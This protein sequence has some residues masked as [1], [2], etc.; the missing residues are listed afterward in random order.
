MNQTKRMILLGALA[1]AALLAACTPAANG[2]ANRASGS[3]ALSSDDALLYAVDTDNGILAVIDTSTNAK[4][5]EV[6]VGKGPTR[7]LVGADDTIYV[8]NRGERTVSVISRGDWRVAKTLD[9]AVEPSGMALTPDGKT[10]LVVSAT[11]RTL[12]E[13]G[14]LTAF[15]TSTLAM[16]WELNV[17]NEPRGV[18]VVGNGDRAVVSLLKSSR[19]GQGSDVVEV[20]L[21][22]AVVKQETLGLYNLANASRDT[23]SFG[24]AFS[25]FRA[26]AMNDLIVTPDGSRVFAPVV[27]ARE[28]AIGR[29]PTSAGGY[30]SAGG[31]CNIGAV[32]TAGIVTVETSST[33][34]PQV[35]DLTACFTVGTNSENKDYPVSTLAPR[36]PG[37]GDAIQGPTVG[38]VD[39]TGT[40]LFVV[41]RESQNVAIMPTYRRTGNDLDFNRTGTSVRSLVRVGAGA[42]G[43]AL[44]RDGTKAF[45]YS[46]FDHRVDVLTAKGRGDSAEVVNLGTPIE[47]AKDP[48]FNLDGVIDSKDAN[49]AAGRRLFFDA[50][51][52]RMS[53]AQTNVACSTCHLEGREDGHVWQF[54]DGPRQTPALAGRH[55][56]RTA[57]YHWS[58][59]FTSLEAFN[60]HTITERMGGSGLPP[61]AA[62]N[63]DTYIDQLPFGENPLKTSM[64][65]EAVARGQ[66][67]FEK[68]G[69]ASCHSGE[70]FTNNQ[71]ADVGTLNR[72]SVNADNGPVESRGFNVPSLLGVGRTAP[73]LHDGTQGTLEDRIFNN[74]GDRHG[75][76]S[77]L[78][79]QE[80]SDLVLFLKSL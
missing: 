63:L 77:A 57:P 51:D 46:Q 3:L 28:D 72:N 73:Y 45:V 60:V 5:A 17:G 33:P 10:L 34:T 9:V 36:T 54:P 25:T 59:E 40:W 70:L 78:S 68:A 6:K 20:D 50:M 69:C 21:T 31:P 8:S 39:P 27:W 55:L 66:A 41:N 37:S 14:T 4:V 47:I 64:P 79:E 15:D 67:A 1:G 19:F 65:S 12:V 42:D 52:T 75:V 44:T 74:P 56:L 32:A 80:K 7:V 24:S 58:G 22:N 43:I 48:D 62:Q 16:K 26:R 29:R 76:T 61:A 2:N 49:L 53:S 30:Y 35:D 13:V 71:N 38:V 11:S 18:A 23:S